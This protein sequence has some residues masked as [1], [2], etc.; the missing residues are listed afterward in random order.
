MGVPSPPS[1]PRR[2]GAAH[3]STSSVSLGLVL[4]GVV[5]LA[6]VAVGSFGLTTEATLG[7]DL[8]TTFSVA[9]TCERGV[10]TVVRVPG[11][12]GTHAQ[13]MP[14][15]VYFPERAREAAVVGADAARRRDTHPTRVVYDAKRL[16]GRRV[17]DPAVAEESKHLPF[18]VVAGDGGFAAIQLGEADDDTSAGRHF[19][20]TSSTIAP[21]AVGAA[22]LARLK[23]AAETAGDGGARSFAKR[24][25]GFR[26]RTVTVS[27][28]VNFS[29]EQKAATLR[30]ARTAGFAVARLLEE[31][32]AAAVAHDATRK[33]KERDENAAEKKKK[34][35]ENETTAARS[36]WCTTWAA[37]RWMSRCSARSPRRERSWSWARRGTTGSGGRI[38]TARCFSGREKNCLPCPSRFFFQTRA[39]QSATRAV[40][41]AVRRRAKRRMTR[42]IVPVIGTRLSSRQTPRGLTRAAFTSARSARWNSPRDT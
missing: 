21:E 5:C 7:I 35:N 20:K 17:D 34:P 39:T 8:G 19:A 1:S 26:F 36:C 42:T 16:I 40:A 32:V 25:L 9:A 12:S 13:T 23:A 33:E 41:E 24:L 3:A 6:A 37:G 14:S 27:V 38:S 15:V 18:A 10:V 28:P 4:A 11:G 2:A 30:A 29:N 22:I 31:P